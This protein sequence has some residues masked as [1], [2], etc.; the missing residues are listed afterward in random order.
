MLFYYKIDV[1]LSL[2]KIGNE[3]PAN[4]NANTY[5]NGP[6]P[7]KPTHTATKLKLEH[8]TKA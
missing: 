3:L 8:K 6:K 5:P 4:M 2:I 7:P 1:D